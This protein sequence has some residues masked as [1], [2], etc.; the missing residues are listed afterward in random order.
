MQTVNRSRAPRAEDE[1]P[2][3]KL[4]WKTSEIGNNFLSYYG[5]KV[6]VFPNSRRGGWTVSVAAN[7]AKPVYSN[8]ATEAQARAN[9]EC[10]FRE[11]KSSGPFK[12]PP[13]Q[14]IQETLEDILINGEIPPEAR[15]HFVELDADLKREGERADLYRVRNADGSFGDRYWVPHSQGVVITNNSQHC[16]LI[17]TRWW[18]DRAE[19][20]S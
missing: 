20:L 5:L 9:A 7:G 12:A 19:A 13:A 4:I 14:S 17:V 10:E 2:S 16:R 8:Y 15:N 18:W 1:M 11:L 6:T 3:G